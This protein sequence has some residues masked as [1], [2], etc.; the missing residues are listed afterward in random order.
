MSAKDIHLRK[1][2]KSITSLLRI[3]QYKKFTFYQ[4]DYQLD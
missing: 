1:Y 2:T 3:K 4:I